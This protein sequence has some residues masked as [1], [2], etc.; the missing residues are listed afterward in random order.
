MSNYHIIA[1]EA[2]G[3]LHGSN[4]VKELKMLDPKANFRGWGGDLMEANGV[5][6]VEHYRNTAFMG[7]VEV[8]KNIRTIARLLDKCKKDL[9]KNRPD[10]LILIDYPG[11]NLRIAEFAFQNNIP[12]HYYISPQV[13]AWKQNRVKKIKKLVDKMYVILPFEKDFYKKWDYDVAFVGHPLLDAISQT[14]KTS[15][16]ISQELKIDPETSIV[17]ML[18]GSRKQE[19]SKMLPL[20]IEMN[21]EFPERQFVIAGAP[22]ISRKFYEDIIAGRNISLI[23][24]KTYKLLQIADAALV[25][26]GT[27]TLETAL[28]KV[29]QVVC[30]KGNPLSY[31]IGKRLVK[32]KYISLV[33]LI[34]DKPLVK[35]LIQNDFSKEQLTKELQKLLTD[36]PYRSNI[37]NEYKSLEKLLGSGGASK[38]VAELIYQNKKSF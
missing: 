27:A 7:F 33:N 32:V 20:M 12:V 23:E 15:I 8:V 17:A 9:L 21:E 24:N 36:S 29:P 13:W 11:F 6:L 19:I 22:N 35:E 14:K 34:L 30:Y 3:D 28:F 10:V 31:Q 16:E 4:L 18:P 2:S 38:K 25:T 5:E 37:Q 26:S 1:G